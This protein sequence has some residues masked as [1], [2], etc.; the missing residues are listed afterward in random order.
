MI[1]ATRARFFGQT[2]SIQ[3]AFLVQEDDG[4]SAA[5]LVSVGTIDILSGETAVFTEEFT[6][7][8]R[9]LWWE[10]DQ[11]Y[12]VAEDRGQFYFFLHHPQQQRNLNARV[13]VTLSDGRTAT[14]RVPVDVQQDT[15]GTDWQNPALS[16]REQI[17]FE[18]EPDFPYREVS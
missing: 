2:D 13:T 4:T 14:D 3:V 18:R 17:N 6:G 12:D 11:N 16:G 8:H 10:G 15:D 9:V 5:P 7:A 1:V